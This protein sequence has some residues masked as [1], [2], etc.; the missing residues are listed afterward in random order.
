MPFRTIPPFLGR[1]PTKRKG[2]TK[3]AQLQARTCD[4]ARSCWLQ[5]SFFTTAQLSHAAPPLCTCHTILAPSTSVGLPPGQKGTFPQQHAR[6][7]YS[8]PSTQS[9]AHPH[10]VDKSHPAR[11]TMPHA[12]CCG[13]NRY[14]QRQLLLVNDRVNWS[15]RGPAWRGSTPPRPWSWE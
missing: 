13:H 1:H 10:A 3:T 11:A 12:W 6:V 9:P 8:P 7:P 5:T 14:R 4:W 2:Q 15:T